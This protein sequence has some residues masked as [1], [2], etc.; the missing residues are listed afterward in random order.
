MGQHSLNGKIVSMKRKHTIFAA[1]IF[2]LTIPLAN[3]QRLEESP[4]KKITE[5][6]EI[7][8]TLLPQ[9]TEIEGWKIHSSPQFFEPQNLWEYINGQAEMYLDYGFE[10]VATAEYTTLDGMRSMT[11]EIYQMQSPKHAFGIYAA[12]RSSDDRFIKMGVQGY[13]SE[14]VLN[15]WKGLYYV[16]L[17]S[18]QTSSE[19][20]EILMKLAIVIDHKIEGSYSEPELFACFPEDNKVKMSERFIP[21]NFMGLSFLKDGYQVEY[22]RAGSSYPVFLVKNGSQDMA[23]EV[24]RKYQDFLKSQHERVSHSKKCD[25]QLIFTKR[26]KVEVMFQYGS[27]VG[28]ILNSADLSKAERIIEEIVQKLK[29]GCS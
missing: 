14:N 27:F 20:K 22:M 29:R 16:K 13:L 5:Y 25:Y 28:G 3:A 11:I 1:I 18:F 9:N 6:K 21:K 12:E 4:P 8:G 15:F 23:K 2:A 7:L 10:L 24:F 19:T 17:T 26:E